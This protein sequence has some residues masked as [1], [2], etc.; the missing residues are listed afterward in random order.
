MEEEA[1]Q[2]YIPI[3]EKSSIAFLQQ[4]IRWRNVKRILELGTAIGYSAIKM[5]IAA[6]PNA[7]IVTIERDREM[8]D[9]A[10][11]NI[12]KLRFEDSIQIVSGDAMDE[13]EPVAEL[14]PYDLILIDAA[15]AQYERLFLKYTRYIEPGGMIV[16]DNV[17]FHGLVCNL[18][19]IKK[20][21][22]HGLV[23][24][25]DHFNHF[26]S[27]RDEFDTVFLTVGD[28]LAVST[29]KPLP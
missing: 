23:R 29:K 13:L 12:Q 7:K 21:Q 19:G 3:M 17:F 2:V 10:V 14:A 1:R 5:R 26:L 15:K 25:V 28:G 18:D 4:L 20:R 16:V 24:K 22:L 9:E 27:E 11:K 8:I 6:G